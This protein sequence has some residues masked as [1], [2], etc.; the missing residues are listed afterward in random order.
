MKACILSI[1]NELLQG[2]TLNT[3]AHNLSAPLFD[4]GWEVDRHISLPDRKEDFLE[5]MEYVCGTYPLVLVTGGLGPT[6]DDLTRFFLAEFCKSP[7]EEKQEALAGIAAWF[8][9]RNRPMLELNR[10]QALMPQIASVLPNPVGTAPGIGITIKGTRLFFL[11]GVP[12]E[13]MYIFN[14]S[15][16][17]KIA[18]PNW[19]KAER[20]ILIAGIGE[21]TLTD[22]FKSISLP[23]GVYFASLPSPGGVILRIWSFGPTQDSLEVLIAETMQLYL[24]ALEPYKNHIVSAT[25]LT[26]DAQLHKLLLTNNITV[27]LAES[28]TGGGL[29]ARLS[30]TPGSSSY[31]LGGIIAYSNHIKTHLLDVPPSTLQEF[32]AVSEETALAMAEG[33]RKKFNAQLSLSITG[34]AGPEGGTPEKPVGTICFGVSDEN[35]SETC[36]KKFYGSRH[37]IRLKAEYFAIDLLRRKILLKKALA[38]LST[39]NYN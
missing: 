4:L 37:E 31:F 29:G 30:A 2:N 23:Y 13:A 35:I 11:P 14:A 25:E 3:N 21:S 5:A 33:V 27:C 34:I 15:I 18:L 22:L 10:V 17:P 12:K 28:C 6:P 24:F 9:A 26:P 7:L 20:T 1:G 8:S 32:G 16:L 39:S 36:T 38:H 19:Y